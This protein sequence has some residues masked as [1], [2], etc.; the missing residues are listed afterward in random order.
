MFTINYEH[1]VK[2]RRTFAIISHPDAGKTTVTEKML[3][4]G[5][6]IHMAGTVKAKGSSKY[7]R[8]DWM[9]IE[10]RRGISV[11]TS[12]MQFSYKDCIINLLDTPGHEDF[13]EDTYRILTAVDF[14]IM[15]IDAAK[16]VE[17]R[18]RKLIEVTRLKKTP[19]ITFINK[20]DRYCKNYISLLDEIESDLNIKCI[21]INWPI[22][23][24]TSFY[25]IYNLKNKKIHTYLKKKKSEQSQNNLSDSIKIFN[26][27]SLKKIYEKNYAEEI[28]EELQLI[29]NVYDKHNSAEF[30]KS[31][32]TPV[33]FGTALGNFG[34]DYML[35][36]VVK[37][38]PSPSS[39]KTNLRIVNPKES[40]VTGFVFKIQANMDLRH[41]DRIAFLRIV[42]GIFHKGMKL[43]NIRTGKI[44]VLS[45]AVYFIAGER[46][47]V[48]SAYPGDVIGIHNH[49]TI[50]IGDTFTEGENFSFIEIPLFAP[51]I[52]KKV[53]LKNPLKKK[54]LV[55]GLIELSEEGTIQVFRK[56]D[57]N[58]IFLG[59]I[60]SLQFEVVLDRLRIEYKV[61]IAYNDVNIAVI[62][63]IK[64]K[65]KKKLKDFINKYSQHL[66]F[67]FKKNL[68]YIATN[69][70]NL[71][72]TS[73]LN[74]EHIS[75][76]ST[77]NF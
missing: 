46:R 34:I 49:G 25:G 32:S 53:L 28:Y 14:C 27:F 62:R 17:E 63:W 24:G 41:R 55:K 71:K 74:K 36:Y 57:S 3:F 60:G 72:I 19:I 18:T 50:N 68:V 13:S 37:Y 6:V 12:V 11:T 16:G 44:F 77:I 22:G 26:L 48:N 23:S 2:T 61:D 64:C 58:T 40:F 52:F 31:I 39:R 30:L 59:A 33:F 47:I 1:R 35:D 67:D 8:S 9:E 38:A 4:L 42:S 20:L 54:Q 73:D 45:D 21:P 5:K 10:K 43:K 15:I 69:A 70:A 75:F 29:E 51:E 7:A 76:S 56:M 65:S 66:A